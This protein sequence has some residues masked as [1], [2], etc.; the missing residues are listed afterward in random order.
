MMVVMVKMVVSDN[1]VS[2]LQFKERGLTQRHGRLQQ[3]KLLQIH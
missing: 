3:T 1:C 2:V